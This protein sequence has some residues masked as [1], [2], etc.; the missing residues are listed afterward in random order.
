MYHRKR[1][2]LHALYVQVCGSQWIRGKNTVLVTFMLLYFHAPVDIRAPDMPRIPCKAT[3]ILGNS[4]SWQETSCLI[5]VVRQHWFWIACVTCSFQISCLWQL[6]RQVGNTCARA[7]FKPYILCQL[8]TEYLN[9][10]NIGTS[11][12]ARVA[13]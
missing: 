5:Y 9:A 4:D 11:A 1:S 6:Y 12:F 2:A 10:S 13:A 3:T 7:Y 8:E